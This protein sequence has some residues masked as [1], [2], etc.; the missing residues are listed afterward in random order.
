MGQGS[1]GG[2]LWGRGPWGGDLWGR[3]P[4]VG[5]HG[6]GIHGAGIHGAG[7]PWGGD[8]WV[9]IHGA[10]IYGAWIYGA[11]SLHVPH[12]LYSPPPV[13]LPQLLKIY[14]ARS[15]AGLSVG[16][17]GLELLALGGSVAYSVGHGFPFR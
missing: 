14:G 5:I 7:D 1:M 3:G 2:D 12:P 4:W 6:A 15:G 11:E 13:K 16:A 17:V 10:G 9:G 8:P